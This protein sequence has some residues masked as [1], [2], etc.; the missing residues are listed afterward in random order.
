MDGRIGGPP[1]NGCHAASGASFDV[2]SPS[3]DRVT[4]DLR[5]I[6]PAVRAAADA[7]QVT[8]ATFCREA[9]VEAAGSPIV[10]TPL[11]NDDRD[12][13]Q[14]A[15]LT[16]RLPLPDAELLI[17]RAAALGMS[18]GA[19]VGRLVRN[20]PLPA[21]AADRAADRTALIASVDTLNELAADLNALNRMLRNGDADGV[22]RYRASA[23][24]LLTNVRR[25]LDLASRV[26]AR[27]GGDP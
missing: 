26:I 17:R 27:N 11:L 4:I 21:P 5:R 16:L 14:S 1:V 13:S 15:K 3:R 22:S 9:L 12:R 6:G 7:R 24:S 2:T 25:H 23:M 10:P 18:Y 20:A 8:V 19:F